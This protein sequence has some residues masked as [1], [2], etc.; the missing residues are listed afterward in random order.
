MP[1]RSGSE[2]S[3]YR[4][5]LVPALLALAFT[6]VRALGEVNHWSER[7]F[8]PVTRGVIPSTFGWVFGVTWLAAPFGVYFALELSAGEQGP[9]SPGKA[10]FGGLLS[11]SIALLG[12][13]F[14]VPFAARHLFQQNLLLFLIIIWSIEVIAA[15]VHVWSWPALFKTLLA[16]GIASRIPVVVVYF[17]AM[18]GNWGTHYDYVDVPVFRAMPLTQRFLE[19]AVLPQLI[20]W[21]AFTIVLGA[22]CGSIAVAVRRRLKPSLGA[23]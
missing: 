23:A 5:I 6:I 4:L 3:L 22:F 16:Y 1:G 8:E 19:T 13:W 9:G 11:L 17:L 2:A 15:L 12:M 14:L 21:V 7:W 20:F 10:V 18:R